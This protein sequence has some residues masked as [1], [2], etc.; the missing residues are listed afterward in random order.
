MESFVG[1]YT[2]R[3]FWAGHAPNLQDIE[4]VKD[5]FLELMSD[6]VFVYESSGYILKICKDGMVLFQ[7]KEM[8]QPLDELARPNTPSDIKCTIKRW[9]TYLDYLNCIYLLLDSSCITELRCAYFEISEITN[10]DAFTPTFKNGKFKGGPLSFESFAYHFQMGRHLSSYRSDMPLRFDP[11]IGS[12]KEIPKIVFDTLHSDFSKAYKDYSQVRN[13]AMI[14]KSLGEYKVANYSTSLIL[15]WFVIEFGL[16]SY[17]KKLLD[18]KNTPYENENKRISSKRMESF[19]GRDYPISVTLNLL[20]LFDVIDYPTF[21][22]IDKVRKVRNDIVHNKASCE[23]ESC[24]IS[25]DII[26]QFTMKDTG[27]N[28]EL[29]LDYSI[30]GL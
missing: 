9:G 7:I 28:L 18:S 25:F 1:F 21:C 20:E 30:K 26:K 19:T 23:P 3:P 2:S 6:E 12:R 14:T 8:A 15:S 17:W 16:S 27:I 4:S 10:R 22:K 5:R 13:L 24:Q 29:S 11:R